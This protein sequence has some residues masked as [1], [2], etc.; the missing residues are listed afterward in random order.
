MVMGPSLLQRLVVGGL[1]WLAAV[2]CWRLAVFG[3]LRLV[4]PL[5]CPKGFP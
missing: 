2:G 4:V 5:G 1:R 3:G